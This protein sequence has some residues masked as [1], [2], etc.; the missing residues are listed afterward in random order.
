MLHVYPPTLTLNARC[1]QGG[2][3]HL[4]ASLLPHFLAYFRGYSSSSIPQT[5]T[6]CRPIVQQRRGGGRQYTRHAQCDQCQVEDHNEPIAAVDTL[7][8]CLTEPA[9]RYQCKKVFRGNGDVGDLPGDGCAGEMAMPTTT[10]NNPQ[11]YW[12]AFVLEYLASISV[13]SAFTMKE[14]RKHPSAP[15]PTT[16]AGFHKA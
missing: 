6:Q 8:Q 9:Q 5:D 10:V 4:A 7:H 12:I 3:K 13:F 15:I 11:K 1:L 14:Y 2:E 16:N